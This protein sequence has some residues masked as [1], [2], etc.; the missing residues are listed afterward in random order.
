MNLN[1]A[2]Y[3]YPIVLSQGNNVPKVVKDYIGAK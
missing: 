2:K 3:K 1:A